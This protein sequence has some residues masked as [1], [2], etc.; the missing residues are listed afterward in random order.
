MMSL[1]NIMVKRNLGS[2]AASQVTELQA[3]SSSL[4]HRS[5]QSFTRQEQIH[6]KV[7]SH[8]KRGGE[9]GEGPVPP[10]AITYHLKQE[11]QTE[12]QEEHT[13]ETMTEGAEVGVDLSPT[14]GSE[15]QAPHFLQDVIF[16]GKF[17][18]SVS[19]TEQTACPTHV[20]D[21]KLK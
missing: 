11:T 2:E 6:R 5:T 9:A 17:K 15:Q 3:H 21:S 7:A 19:R 13:A 1:L 16:H 10:D 14:S 4:R 18:V 20:H 8:K 12:R